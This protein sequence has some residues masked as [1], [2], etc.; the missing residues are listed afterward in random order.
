VGSVGSKFANRANLD[1]NRRKPRD[2]ASVP[3]S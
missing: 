2:V 1:I 3:Q